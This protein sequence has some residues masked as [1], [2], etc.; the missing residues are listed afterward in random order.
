M[1]EQQWLSSEDPIAL[2]D[3]LQRPGSRQVGSDVSLLSERKL[4]LFACACARLFWQYALSEAE[5]SVIDVAEGMADDPEGRLIDQEWIYSR[6]RK[7]GLC[8]LVEDDALHVAEQWCEFSRGWDGFVRTQVNLLRDIAGN[9]FRPATLLYSRHYARAVDIDIPGIAL[10]AY[11]HR[12]HSGAL[13][14]G[15]LFVLADA[16]EEAWCD[17]VGILTHLRSSGPHVRGCWALDCIFGKE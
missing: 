7:S 2:L 14:P 4:R 17:N 9:P 15:R 11:R 12:Q 10:D 16:L 1:L 13:D 5:V 8:V 6:T 3:F